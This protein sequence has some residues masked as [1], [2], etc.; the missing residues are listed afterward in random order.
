M[1]NSEID[2]LALKIPFKD[3]ISNNTT[4]VILKNI[5]NKY[6]PK[7]LFDR[8]KK[9]FGIP[10]RQFLFQQLRDWSKSIIFDKYYQDPFLDQSQVEKFWELTDKNKIDLSSTIWSII[11]FRVWFKE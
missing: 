6:I 7:K 1:I 2:N 8:P 10:I 11:S 4:K 9:G 5:L 3:K